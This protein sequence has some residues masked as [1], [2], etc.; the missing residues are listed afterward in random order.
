MIILNFIKKIG[1]KTIDLFKWIWKEC[2]DW[3]TL[4]I[5]CI[6]WCFVMSPMIVG[7]ILYLITKNAWH[8]TYANAWILFWAGPFTPAIPLC[9]ALTL[10][11]K[12]IFHKSKNNKNVS[13]K[14]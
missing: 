4:V 3:R 13:Q 5:F 10:G 14:D 1:K 11:I 6:V 12:N 2:K 9:I 7:Y 8:L